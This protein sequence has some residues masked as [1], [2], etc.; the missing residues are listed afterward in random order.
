MWPWGHVGVAYILYSLYSRGRFRRPPRP[1]A[2]LAVVFGSQ[3]A[4]LLDKPLAVLGVL[5]HGRFLAH[6]LLGTAVLLVVVYGAAV[7]LARVDLA[8]AFVVGHLSHL[9]VDIPPRAF[10]G[11]P[12][13]TEFLFWPVLSH[14]TFMFYE[15]LFEPPAI[16]ELVVTPLT[17][18]GLF[19]GL[20]IL[21]FGV[22]LT[23]W[24]IDGCPGLRYVRSRF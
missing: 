19:M 10:L 2:A 24:A 12:A 8:T 1:E 5:P 4:D 20:E 13:N 16:V 7:A 15:R 11:Y 18:P 14:P 9:V 17:Y 6:S 22:G 21:L 23:L 3:F